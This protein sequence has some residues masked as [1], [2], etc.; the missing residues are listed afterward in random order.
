MNV[1][2]RKLPL[3]VA[4]VLL[5][6]AL[7]TIGVAFGLWSKVMTIDGTVNTGNLQV[8]WSYASSGDPFGAVDTGYTK[9]VGRLDCEIDTDPQILR[10]TVHNGYPSY[11][12]DCQVEYTNTGSI[13]VN[14]IG[15]AIVPG[16]GL[17]NC[18]L[19]DIQG[20]TLSCDQLTIIFVDNEGQQMDPGWKF[21][22]SV[23]IHVEQ[24]AEQE[25]IYDFDVVLCA[26]QWNEAVDY[27]ACVGNPNVEGP[28]PN[29]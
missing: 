20:D 12:A 5:V 8:D 21:A 24:P 3:G 15:F 9:D 18:V 25:A 7:T 1:R 11:T 10:F 28:L 2:K 17:T 26:A 13:P 27:A 23:R 29:G 6:L 16:V 4:A 14:V 19:D 22:S